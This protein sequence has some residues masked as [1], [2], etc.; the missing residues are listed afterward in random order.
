MNKLAPNQGVE[1][2]VCRV[3]S[4]TIPYATLKRLRWPTS[5]TEKKPHTIRELTYRA[6]VELDPSLD[7]ACMI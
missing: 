4:Y 3:E 2:G 7:P 6:T 1:K 5:P